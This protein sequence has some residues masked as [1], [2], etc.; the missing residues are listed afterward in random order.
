MTLLH[1]AVEVVNL[2]LYTSQLTEISQHVVSVKKHVSTEDFFTKEVSVHNIW[3]ALST[4]CTYYCPDIWFYH[5]LGFCVIEMFTNMFVLLDLL[6][7]LVLS[8]MGRR[9]HE[10]FCRVPVVLSISKNHRRRMQ[11]GKLC[12]LFA[13]RPRNLFSITGVESF[14][15]RTNFLTMVLLSFALVS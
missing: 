6:S 9:K 15:G 14:Y 3:I 5:I 13:T 12:C 4:L 8:C 11:P 1:N 7:I 10:L 2:F